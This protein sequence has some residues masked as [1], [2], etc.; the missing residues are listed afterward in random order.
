MVIT[1]LIVIFRAIVD[2]IG[3][4]GNLLVVVTV[5]VESR[6]YIMCYVLLASPGVSDLLG[7]ILT[8]TYNLDC[9]I[10]EKWLYSETLCHLLPS[11]ARYFYLNTVL[12]LVAVSYERYIAIVKEPLTY[13]GTMTLRKGSSLALLWIIS[14]PFCIGPFFG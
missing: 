1:Q 13:D 10:Q 14:I 3:L 4:S 2:V 5:S 7:L 9:I 12:H 11:F 6:L 8:N